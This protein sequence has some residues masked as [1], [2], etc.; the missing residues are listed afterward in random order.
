MNFLKT[1]LILSL[2]TL[3]T[4]YAHACAVDSVSAKTDT[5]ISI[6]W[7]LSGC[8]H[9]NSGSKFEICKRI[10]FGSWSCYL[11]SNSSGTFALSGLSPSTTYKIRTKWHKRQLWHEVTTRTVTTDPSPVATGTVLRYQ[12]LPGNPYCVDFYWKNPPAPSVQWTLV[13][14]LKN[15][16][17]GIWGSLPNINLASAQFNSSTNEYSQQKCGFSN[18]RQYRA[19]I[20]QHSTIGNSPELTASNRVQWK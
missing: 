1:F 16:T 9:V 12:K 8:S 17:I 14:D 20:K 7:D 19:F 2:F 11:D 13:M 5:T 3:L 6:S 15:R 10:G 4:S 18:N